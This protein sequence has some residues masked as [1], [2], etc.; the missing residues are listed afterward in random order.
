MPSLIDI[1]RRI[2]A[3]KTTQQ[4]TKAMKMVAASQAAPRAGAHRRRAPVRAADAAGAEQPGRARRARR[5]TRCCAS[6]GRPSGPHA[7]DRDHRRPGLCGSFNANIIKAAGAVRRRTRRR[8][9]WRWALVGRKG[10]DFFRRR[11]F[12]VRY[13]D[14]GIFQRA[15]ATRTRRRS[16]TRAIEEFTAG[17]VSTRSTSSTTSS[18]RVMHAA[19]RRRAAAADPAARRRGRR[20]EARASTTST[21]RRPRRSSSELLPRHVRDPG[22]PRAARVGGRRARRAHDG[23]GRG[24]AQRAAR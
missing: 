13:E 15:E 20:R 1:R 18:S 6:A 19:R 7:A 22:L 10:R 12:D 8:G 23:D 2:R 24:D 4:I 9:R 16:P 17:R 3:V 5:R 11:G 21:S 14:V